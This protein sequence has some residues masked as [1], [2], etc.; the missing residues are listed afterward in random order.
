MITLQHAVMKLRYL[1]CPQGFSY[2]IQLQIMYGYVA[3]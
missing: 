1:F 2:A 3:R